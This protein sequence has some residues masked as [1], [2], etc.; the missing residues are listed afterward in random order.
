MLKKLG[1]HKTFG[2]WVQNFTHPSA[3]INGDMTFAIYLPPQAESASVPVLYWL[4]GLTCNHENFMQ[5]AGAQ[6]FAAKYGV[7]LVAPDTSP[8]DAG[9]EG[10]DDAY[11][12]GSGAGFY[13]DATQAPWSAQYKMYS[14]IT[15]ELPALIEKE[16]P[17][18]AQ[19]SISGHS[20]GGHG[21]LTIALK[22]PTDFCSVSA[23]A[24]ICS[25][26]RCPWGEKALGG[27][28]G[29]NREHWAQYDATLLI[30]SLTDDS[31]AKKLP[32]LV[33]QGA[34]DD[35]LVEQLKPELLA[36][37]AERKGLSLTLRTHPGFDH[38]YYFVSSFIG[39]HLEFHARA[40]AG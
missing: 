2:G 8:R 14:Y 23:F 22:N 35:F 6:Q 12:F 39:E 34:D 28:L 29:D 19:R 18:T 10:E 15:Q 27:Y 30:D 13:V 17:V 3:M 5:K 25:P 26:T 37:S 1:Q 16:F 38:S 31:A 9:I 24:P 36:E 7:A 40:L 11:D 4:S 33:D 32:W 21:A 20:M